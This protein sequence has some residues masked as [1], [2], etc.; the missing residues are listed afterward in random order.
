MVG[1]ALVSLGLLILE[2][3][4]KLDAMQLRFVE[5][6]EIAIG[7]LFLIEFIFEWYYAKDK[8]KYWRHHWF[9]LLAAIPIPAATFEVL[10]SIRIVRLLRFL[11]VFAHLGY[12]KNTR[13][14]E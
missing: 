1:L 14:F 8:S 2:H 6:F 13:L 5:G 10:R 7:I 9:Y 12:E 3:F 11:K 4:E